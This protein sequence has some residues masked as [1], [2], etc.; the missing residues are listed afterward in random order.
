MSQLLTLLIFLLS[1][2]AI[3]PLCT[4]KTWCMST[5]D[6]TDAQ[7]QANIDW[8]C[9]KG[10]VDCRYITPGGPCYLPDTLP[11]HASW[12]MNTYYQMRRRYKGA[13]DWGGTGQIILTDPSY[14][15]CVYK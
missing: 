6:A 5:L 12:V 15:I 11:A 1:L 4:S 14:N 2:V 13:C 10:R 3:Y 7:L 9:S 8:G